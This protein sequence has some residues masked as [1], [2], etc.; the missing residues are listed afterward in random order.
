VVK[1]RILFCGNSLVNFT[2]LGY[3]AIN[4]LKQ[5]Y[6]TKKYELGYNC[7]AG[8]DTVPEDFL[9]FGKEFEELS[10]NVVIYNC[11]TDDPQK[12]MMFDD[13]VVHDFNPDVV[14]T[15]LDPWQMEQIIYSAYKAN[16]HLI[17]YL[18]VETPDFPDNMTY[19]TAYNPN[20]RKSMRNFMKR[21]DTIIPVTKMGK[22]ALEKAGLTNVVDNIYNGLDF[23]RRCRIDTRKQEIFGSPL[24]N[25]D[26]FIFM[27]MGKN[28]ERKKIDVTVRAFAE[29]L[30]QVD[31]P[32]NY[33]LYVHSNVNEMCG[34]TDIM[35]LTL[36]LGIGDNFIGQ[37][38]IKGMP[39][40]SLQD[41]YRRYSAIDCYIALPSGEGFCYG[42][43]EAMMH[44]KPCIYIDYGG[45]AE[46]LEDIG[47]PV[48]VKEWFYARNIPMKWALAD[49]DDAVQ[50][51]LRVAKDEEW[52]K[53][54]GQQG[55]LQAQKFEW[56]IIGKQFVEAIEESASTF[57]KSS[58][59]LKRIL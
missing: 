32:E 52:R 13:E 45:H 7:V 34:G 4:F 24:V 53:W 15:F 50:Q 33:K 12:T 30:K 17:S 9:K 1:K 47:L 27:T 59:N 19:P 11:Q 58:F 21:V 55:F 36:D 14:I 18:T 39:P 10:K 48:K 54:A 46:Y 5:C 43:A 3:V 51:M 56:G 44:K 16:F 28:N 42:F 41:L 49:I 23:K 35:S 57:I 6:N 29:F 8:N 37:Q 20:F 38:V 22:E 2:G 40:M 31:K 25:D 26:T